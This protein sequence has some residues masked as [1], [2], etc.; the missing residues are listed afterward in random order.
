MNNKNGNLIIKIVFGIILVFSL[1]LIISGLTEKEEVQDNPTNEVLETGLN[2]SPTSIKLEVGGEQEVNVSIIPENA[3]YKNINYEVGN[4]NIIS[5][6]NGVV[7]GISPGSTIIKVTTE[8]QKIT[9]I[10]NVTVVANNVPVTEIKPNESSIE[11]Y[12]GDTKKIEY[13]VVPDH[14]TNKKVSLSTKNKEVAAFNQDGMLVGVSAG[15]TN[16]ILKNGDVSAKISVTVKNKDIDISSITLTPKT[17]ELKVGKIKDI[18]VTYNPSNATNKN[19][20]WTSSDKKIATVDNGNI[21]AISPGSATITAT[22]PNGKTDTVTVTV[23]EE[24]KDNKIHFI[25]QSIKTADASDAILIES[26]GHFAMVDT[27]MQTKEDNQFVYNYLKNVGVKELDFILITH[28]HDDHVGGAVYLINSDIKVKKF[29]IKTYIGRDSKSSSGKK[30][31]NAIIDALK[32]KNIPVTY[33]DKT[34]TDGKGF[35]FYDMDFKLYNTQQVMNQKGYSGGNEN[36]NSVME[37]I[38]VNGKKIFLTGDS[39]SGGIMDNISKTIGKVDVMKM[40][41]HG[42]GTCSMNKE[43]AN[44]LNPSYLIVTNAKINACRQNFNS[45]IPTYY[46]KASKKN[47][48]IVDLTNGIKIID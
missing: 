41:H 37:L 7:K 26:A 8:K 9:R 2:V 25:K 6:D 46:T 20:T 18:K 35:T 3:T 12:V 21:K 48:I 4:S 27:G 38:T 40:P 24:K 47:A 14:A 22:T 16:V 32:K 17:V 43:R 5:F 10:I 34:Y 31:Y 44:R 15:T 13:S 42:Y 39:Y 28:N 19:V 1:Y 11:L 45:N 29:I 23:K 36:N 33:V 30:N